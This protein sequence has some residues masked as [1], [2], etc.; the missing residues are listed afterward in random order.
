MAQSLRKGILTSI[1]DQ[2]NLW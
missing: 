1:I 2:S